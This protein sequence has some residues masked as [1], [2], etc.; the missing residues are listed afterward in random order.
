[1]VD[2]EKNIRK[3]ICVIVVLLLRMAGCGQVVGRRMSGKLSSPPPQKVLV[4]VFSCPEYRSTESVWL[5]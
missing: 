1:M 2:Y 3:P 4:C 5:P